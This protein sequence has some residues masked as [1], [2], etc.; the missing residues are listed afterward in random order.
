MGS[1]RICTSASGFFC[2]A[3]C[4]TFPHV[5]LYHR[6]LLFFIAVCI[7]LHIFLS[8]DYMI[9]TSSFVRPDKEHSE[10]PHSLSPLISG[11]S[12]MYR[13][14]RDSVAQ[15]QT[16]GPHHSLWKADQHCGL[17]LGS[18]SQ[19]W[20]QIAH[21]PLLGKVTMGTSLSLPFFSS[22]IKCRYNDTT[23]YVALL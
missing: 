12:W 20:V 21:L 3:L 1:H 22:S 23:D 13:L 6:S 18:W 2:P 11:F 19:V 10:P 8:V 4:L 17:G 5:V 15:L 16:W 7:P 14:E 9:W